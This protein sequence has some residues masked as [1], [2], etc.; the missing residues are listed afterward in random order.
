MD[1]EDVSNK[2]KSKCKGQRYFASQAP[3]VLANFLIS[4]LLVCARL[5]FSG[6]PACTYWVMQENGEVWCVPQRNSSRVRFK[7]RML[8]VFCF[9]YNVASQRIHKQSMVHEHEP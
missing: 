3:Q 9:W 8:G 4:I 6:C 7:F 5:S 2:I 1:K